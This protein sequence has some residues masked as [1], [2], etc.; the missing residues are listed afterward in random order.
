M[1]TLTARPLSRPLA[2]PRLGRRAATVLAAA[3]FSVLAV[4]PAAFASAK[5]MGDGG[6]LP[7]TPADPPVQI[8]TAGGPAGWQIALIAL[9]AALIGA[10][11]GLLIDRKLSGRRRAV[12]TSL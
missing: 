4:V 6:S 10:A 11:A 12:S 8:I 1:S 7:G 5:P 3:L 9:G 2:R